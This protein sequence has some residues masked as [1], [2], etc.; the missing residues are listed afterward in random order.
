MTVRHGSVI[1]NPQKVR[2]KDD[3]K[4]GK[5]ITYI[6]KHFLYRD[7]VEIFKFLNSRDIVGYLREINYQFSPEEMMFLIH[8]SRTVPLAE[9]HAAYWELIERYPDYPLKERRRAVFRNQT[10]ASFLRIYMQREKECGC[11]LELVMLWD[12]HKFDKVVVSTKVNR[13]YTKYSD[14]FYFKEIEK[15][16]Y[17][18]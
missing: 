18:L 2:T 16:I 1:I 3:L 11:N 7:D 17:D 4:E 10:V 5:D 14:D 12:G 15:V 9:K 13:G 6:A 8:E